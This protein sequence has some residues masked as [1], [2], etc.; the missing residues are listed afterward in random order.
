LIG[1]GGHKDTVFK[2]MSDVYQEFLHTITQLLIDSNIA[3]PEQTAYMSMCFI[4]GHDWAKKLGFGESRNQQ[5][6]DLLLGLGP[7]SL[8]VGP[9]PI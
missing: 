6:A 4:I 7:N 5:M 3:N 1:Q 9:D 2:K 8:S